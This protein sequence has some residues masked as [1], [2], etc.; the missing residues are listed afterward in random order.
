MKKNFLFG[1][2]YIND[3][4]PKPYLISIYKG[5]FKSNVYCPAKL[6]GTWKDYK[7]IGKCET[8]FSESNIIIKFAYVAF[9]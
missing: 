2:E 1:A 5:N 8:E 3:E 9:I 4:C 7:Q 6:A